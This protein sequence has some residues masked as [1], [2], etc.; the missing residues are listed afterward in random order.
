MCF[1]VHLLGNDVL[2]YH[3]WLPDNHAIMAQHGAGIA[4]RGT[5]GSV[6]FFISP[7]FSSLYCFPYKDNTFRKQIY[8]CRI[9]ICRWK[10]HSFQI[11]WNSSKTKTSVKC[12]INLRK[13]TQWNQHLFITLNMQS[14][15]SKGS[16]KHIGVYELHVCYAQENV[17][18]LKLGRGVQKTI[19][20]SMI[21]HMRYTYYHW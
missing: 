12:T 3:Q 16:K 21:S 7:V 15:G 18:H 4:N 11:W 6:P 8:S 10:R 9:G 2:K 5:D 17:S 1:K 14:D 20:V 19:I 13:Y